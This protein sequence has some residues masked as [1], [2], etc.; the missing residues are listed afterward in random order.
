LC[1][2]TFNAAGGI[3]VIP[4]GIKFNATAGLTG[5]PKTI[6]AADMISIHH[7]LDFNSAA[8][9]KSMPQILTNS[10]QLTFGI[11]SSQHEI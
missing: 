3:E 4:H 1:E 7:S 8:G 6:P 5:G 11:N 2:V 10:A 9:L